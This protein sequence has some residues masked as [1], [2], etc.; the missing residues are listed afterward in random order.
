MQVFGTVCCQHIHQ[1]RIQR[2]VL[3][4]IF[5]QNAK[6]TVVISFIHL[7]FASKVEP[8]KTSIGRLVTSEWNRVTEKA[9]F[10]SETFCVGMKKIKIQSCFRPFVAILLHL[11]IFCFLV[12]NQNRTLIKKLLLGGNNDPSMFQRERERQRERETQKL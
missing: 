7:K 8:K 12:L 3:S 10:G 2:W 5:V 11:E 1:S 6:S 4:V 9:C